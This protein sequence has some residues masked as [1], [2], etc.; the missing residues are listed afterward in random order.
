[1][2]NSSKVIKFLNCK[3][4]LSKAVFQPRPET[5]F[6]LKKAILEMK[7]IKKRRID[8]LDIFSGSGCI[9]IAILKNVKNA[10][11][12]FLDIDPKAIEQIKINLKLNKISPER[13]RIFQS[14]LFEKIKK[15]ICQSNKD[16]SLAYDFILAN[17]PY[18]AKERIFEVQDLVKKYEPKISWYGGKGGLKYIFPFLKEAKKYLKENG[19][20]FLEIDPLQKGEIEK[21]LKK[22]NYSNFKFYKD[23]FKKIRYLK[24]KK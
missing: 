4:D 10:F 23:Q 9:G 7:G 6:W 3:I 11:L 22:E 21:I 15:R 19:K 24:I 12:D 18:V 16:S 20:I 17:P 2:K 13:Y 5:G 1:M 14:N 8:L